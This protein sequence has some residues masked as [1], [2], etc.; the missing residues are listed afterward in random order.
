MSQEEHKADK[1]SNTPKSIKPTSILD[2]KEESLAE[3]VK[4]DPN[5]FGKCI[6]D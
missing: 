6:S 3:I 1:E 5:P 4:D 2:S